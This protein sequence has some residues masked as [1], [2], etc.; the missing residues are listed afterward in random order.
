MSAGNQTFSLCQNEY[1]KDD[2]LIK[3]ETWHKNDLGMQENVHKLEPHEWKSVEPVYIDIADR[4]QVLPKDYKPDEDP[5]K[6]KSAKTGRGPLGSNWKKE[7]GKS[8]CPYMCAY[9]L[10]TVKFKWW[11]LQNKVESFIQKQE[12]R[13]FTNFHR[14]LFCWLDR[15]VELSMDDIRRMEEDTKKQSPGAVGGRETQ[16]L[17]LEGWEAGFQPLRRKQFIPFSYFC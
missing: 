17:H 14:Q 7:L 5:A 11:G 16:L 6:F 12:K 9:K 4:G 13:L 10:V 3:I 8:D 1:M 2:F 15:W